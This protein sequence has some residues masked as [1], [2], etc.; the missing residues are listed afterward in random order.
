MRAA[1]E[2]AIELRDHEL[3]S[4]WQSFLAV[5]LPLRATERIANGD[6]READKIWRNGLQSFFDGRLQPRL[7]KVSESLKPRP[8]KISSRRRTALVACPLCKLPN[9]PLLPR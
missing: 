1:V 6:Y 2:R 8:T 5:D 7:D 9:K 4:R 3:L